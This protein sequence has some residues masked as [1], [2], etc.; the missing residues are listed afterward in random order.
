MLNKGTSVKM[1]IRELSTQNFIEASWQQH[2]TF[3]PIPILSHVIPLSAVT[4]NFFPDRQNPEFVSNTAGHPGCDRNLAL[5][6]TEHNCK[7]YTRF[8]KMEISFK[9]CATK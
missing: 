7:L 8:Y 3:P 1:T 2:S 6:L 4:A 9:M 5:R